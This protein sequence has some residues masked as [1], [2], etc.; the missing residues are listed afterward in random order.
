M[1]TSYVYLW[2][3]WAR[4]L[5]M[6]LA[7]L[8]CG[9]QETITPSEPAAAT[10][11]PQLLAANTP[12]ILRGAIVTPSGVL[13][14]GYIGIVAGRIASVSDKQ[15]DI[16]GAVIV[17]IDGV[18]LPGFVDVHN[19]V[20][21]NV[22]PRW[23]PGQTF[24]NWYQWRVDPS[25]L[26]AA[27]QPFDHL[28]ASRFC[29]MNTWGELR[30]LVGGTTSIMATQTNP[31]IHGLVRNLD[32]NS[33]FYGTTEL[34]LEHIINVLGVPPGYRPPGASTVRRRR[35]ILHHQSLLRRACDPCGRG[36]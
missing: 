36:Y 19:H 35:A 5:P 22:L 3:R 9:E 2:R 7:V 4:A 29:E 20:P 8:G 27:G 18:V 23:H 25:Y 6:L 12:F 28:S 16:P 32:L 31:C 13:K 1:R 26:Q 34:N 21:W 15:P 14:H 17:N 11:K 10:L 30:G 33:G 24:T